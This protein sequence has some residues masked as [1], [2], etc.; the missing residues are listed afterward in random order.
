MVPQTIGEK[1]AQERKDVGIQW[2]TRNCAST[3]TSS[4]R[5]AGSRVEPSA[6]SC[7]SPS[8]SCSSSHDTTHYHT[9]LRRMELLVQSSHIWPTRSTSFM[10]FLF[11]LYTSKA[12]TILLISTWYLRSLA[13]HFYFQSGTYS[14]RL[15]LWIGCE[16]YV[17]ILKLRR[18]FFYSAAVWT[19][20]SLSS[21]LGSLSTEAVSR[22]LFSSSRV[23]FPWR[24][25]LTL[26]SLNL[27]RV[28]YSYFLCISRLSSSISMFFSN[29]FL[30]SSVSFAFLN[31]SEV[32]VLSRVVSSSLSLMISLDFSRNL[33]YN[34]LMRIS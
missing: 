26:I 4:K 32:R 21:F 33:A 3:S 2:S 10:L 1:I 14:T 27:L 23:I 18:S 11:I 19:P 25:S 13:S 12:C 8:I 7:C 20:K 15:W 30:I 28:S 31:C 9:F 17:L 5:T 29:M 22:R 6:S 24:C 16:C 34:P